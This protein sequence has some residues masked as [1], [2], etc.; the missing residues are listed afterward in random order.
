MKGLIAGL[1]AAAAVA[2]WTG[3]RVPIPTLKLP[4]RRQVGDAAALWVR[5][6]DT[7]AD[8]LR[9]GAS[10]ASAFESAREDL[11]VTSLEPA[12]VSYAQALAA[13]SRSHH[14]PELAHLGLALDV[15]YTSGAS[16]TSTLEHIADSL[17]ARIEDRAL[18][19]Q[20]LAS[21]KATVVVL[22]CLP[23][24]GAVM[25]AA[26]GGHSISWMTSNPIGRLC[27]IGGLML[28]GIGMWWIR[29][30]V[31]AVAL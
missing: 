6:V 21:T 22:A 28:Q 9:A 25:A 31:R 23:V 5:F 11:A 8:E 7:V 19:G 18:V 17:R 15:A 16:L 10:V 29:H 30:M 4:R 14:L 3:A 26:L 13:V 12:R 24:V 27:L 1:L 2:V 20:E